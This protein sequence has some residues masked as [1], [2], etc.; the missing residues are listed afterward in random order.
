MLHAP[1][2]VRAVLLA[3]YIIAA[4]AIIL[5]LL[6]LSVFSRSKPPSPEPSYEGRTLTQLA[7][8][9]PNAINGN[10]RSAEAKAAVRAIGTNAVPCLLAWLDADHDPIKQA[11]QQFIVGLP[12]L[13][14]YRSARDWALVDQWHLELAP[15]LFATLGPDGAPAIPELERIA[16]DPR[17]HRSAHFA[18]SILGGIGSEAL[19]A[20]Q[21]IA[22]NPQCPL[23]NEAGQEAARLLAQPQSNTPDSRHLP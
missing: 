11:V 12:D 18:I 15:Y 8:L 13:I 2:P 16:A 17:G 7:D 19:P 20:L 4:L 3:K 23:R 10:P 21:R 14:L 9:N 22:R 1:R 5:L 6:L